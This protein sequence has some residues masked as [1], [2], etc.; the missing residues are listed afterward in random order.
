MPAPSPR[1]TPPALLNAVAR[2]LSAWT[3]TQPGIAELNAIGADDMRRIAQDA[4]VSVSDLRSLAMHG[5]QDAD[6]LLRRMA[7]LHLDA[8]AVARSEPAVFRDLQRLCTL[9]QAKGRCARDFG[10]HAHDPAWPGW[11]EYCPNAGTLNMLS[12][13]EASSTTTYAQD[14]RVSSESLDKTT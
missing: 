2:W 10:E 9:C 8:T 5:S 1:W 6:L 14:A 4:G 7:I 3:G 13:V 12:A 11:Q